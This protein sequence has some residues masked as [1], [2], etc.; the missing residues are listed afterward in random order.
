M[1]PRIPFGEVHL[2][3]VMPPSYLPLTV[4]NLSLAGRRVSVEVTADGFSMDGLSPE[5]ALVPEPRLV[6]TTLPC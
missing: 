4:S 5:I 3:P 2:D 6:G 1:E